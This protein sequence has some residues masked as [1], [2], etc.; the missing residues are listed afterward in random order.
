MRRDFSRSRIDY[1]RSDSARVRHRASPLVRATMPAAKLI[2]ESEGMK[3]VRLPVLIQGSEMSSTRSRLKSGSGAMYRVARNRMAWV[4]PLPK[5]E[6]PYSAIPSDILKQLGREQPAT[7]E[8]YTKRLNELL[9]AYKLN[10][11]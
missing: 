4:K 11:G 8:D 9:A 5:V 6:N 3:H 1:V 2:A 10:G 7:K